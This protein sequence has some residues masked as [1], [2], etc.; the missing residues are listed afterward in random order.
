MDIVKINEIFYVKCLAECLPID[1]K[2]S[3]NCGNCCYNSLSWGGGIRVERLSF[4]LILP[5]ELC[6]SKFIII[7]HKA[8]ANFI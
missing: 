2:Y 5:W 7:S 8:E 1:S 3:I 6:Y 4:T